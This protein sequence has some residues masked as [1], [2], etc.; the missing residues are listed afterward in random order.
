MGVECVY[1]VLE[2]AYSNSFSLFLNTNFAVPVAAAKHQSLPKVLPL[3]R[4]HS[5]IYQ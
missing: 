1:F 3:S 5:C 4:R 2:R